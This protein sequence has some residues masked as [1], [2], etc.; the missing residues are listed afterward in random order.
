MEL[1]WL[2]HACFRLR[3]REATVLCDPFQASTGYPVGRWSATIVTI[4]HDHPGHSNA[5]AV[6]GVRKV[7]RGPGEYEIAQ[8]PIIGIGTYHDRQQGRVRGRNTVYLIEVDEVRV[9]HLGDLGH[10]LTPEQ[11]AALAPVD[12]LLV[13]VGGST[14]LDPRQAV[15]TVN[16]LEPR[17][18]V[19]MHYRTPAVQRQDLQP[20]ERFLQEMGSGALEPVARLSVTRSSLPSDPQVVVLDYPRS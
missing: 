2:G 15:E 16:Q 17:I 10:P 3:G 19:P 7:V 12:V 18:I 6:S 11:V 14:T 20:V 13:P 1:T 8:V 5:E 4:S 9:C